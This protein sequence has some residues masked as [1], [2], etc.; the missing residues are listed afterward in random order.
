REEEL[1]SDLSPKNVIVSARHITS[2][3]LKK[4][5][6]LKEYILEK[7]FENPKEEVE[8]FKKIKPEIQGKLIFYNKVFKIESSCPLGMWEVHKNYFSDELKKIE[9]IYRENTCNCP[10]YRYY[11]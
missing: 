10:F 11:S 2:V 9:N 1:R 6:L 4:L 5:E 8:F 3:L 7:G